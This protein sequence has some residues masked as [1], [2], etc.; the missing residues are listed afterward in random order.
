ML[1]VADTGGCTA[2]LVSR[3]ARNLTGMKSPRE[4]GSGN[5]RGEGVRGPGGSQLRIC[6]WGGGGVPASPHLGT[7]AWVAGV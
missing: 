4:R 3:R 1:T 5:E 7:G 2:D 6:A